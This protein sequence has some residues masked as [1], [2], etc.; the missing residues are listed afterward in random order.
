[1]S[2]DLAKKPQGSLRRAN[3]I[4]LGNEKVSS[5][6]T[7]QYWS[8][9]NSQV[10]LRDSNPGYKSA[11]HGPHG[12]AQPLLFVAKE[13]T[14]N[15]LFRWFLL[16]NSNQDGS[17]VNDKA[18]KKKQTRS[19][20]LLHDAPVLADKRLITIVKFIFWR[21]LTWTNVFEFLLIISLAS[22]CAYQ[23]YEVLSDYYN[24]PT[25]VSI[26]KRLNDDFRVDLPAITICN[27]N[28]MSRETLQFKY[29]EL[30]DTHFRAITLGTFYS[31]NNFTLP[32]SPRKKDQQNHPTN[33]SVD[34][35]PS[36]V[37]FET[38]STANDG[39]ASID[40]NENNIK[41][42]WVGKVNLKP[43]PDGIDWVKV[44]RYLS[45]RTAGGSFNYLPTYDLIDS[46]TCANVWGD[47]MPCQ[48]FK[49]ILTVQ[50]AASCVT[51]F[52]DSTI[53]DQQDPA[54]QELDDALAKNPSSTLRWCLDLSEGCNTNNLKFDPSAEPHSDHHHNDNNHLYH[55]L[56]VN[57]QDAASNTSEPPSATDE[58]AYIAHEAAQAQ[59]GK[60]RVEMSNMEIIRL[61][62][63]F[64]LDDY[65]DMRSVPGGWLTVHSN[66]VIG[67][68]NH[69]AYSIEPG[70]WYTYY[71]ERFDYYR[72]PAPYSTKCYNYEENRY[73]AVA[74]RRE[75]AD[76]RSEIQQLIREQTRSPNKLVP[77]YVASLRR[78]SMGGV[79]EGYFL[80]SLEP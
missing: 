71:I 56:S 76:R 63:N 70:S 8:P 48:N 65:A 36:M 40:K 55:N 19:S 53:W 3:N 42:P 5:V 37:L 62:L 51:L 79:S 12:R 68:I 49:R 60:F 34:I 13:S 38:L 6:F 24:Y 29:P 35:K 59:Q 50:R 52:H 43:D 23:C 47:H 20:L 41:F 74:V 9:E 27:N 75:M 58:A 31:V 26:H 72:L 33:G 61:R 21:W 78:R 15:F 16:E 80:D 7:L 39:D 22:L 2:S 28:R 11:R 10:P 64:R 54:V 66:S 30:N 4:I 32:D 69:I 44:G 45:N 67:M 77:E 17:I 25:F 1:M 18:G 73:T 57:Q 46:I 14:I